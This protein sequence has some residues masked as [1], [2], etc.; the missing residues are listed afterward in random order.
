MNSVTT[1]R[2]VTRQ[3]TPQK[4]I[5]D[6]NLNEKKL[7]DTLNLSKDFEIIKTSPGILDKSLINGFQDIDSIFRNKKNLQEKQNLKYNNINIHCDSQT[8][9][10]VNK[11]FNLSISDLGIK[12]KKNNKIFSKKKVI[13]LIII[14]IS[15]LFLYI[16]GPFIFNL[17]YEL[18]TK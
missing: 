12:K 8:N 2:D 14:I 3:L 1:T 10:H 18:K 4:L 17:F 16:G 7:N 11:D 15:C 5:N 6:K 9:L 13:I